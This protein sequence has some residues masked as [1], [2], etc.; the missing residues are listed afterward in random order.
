MSNY[1]GALEFAS[2]RL[3]ND[4]DIALA[5]VSNYGTALDYAS[6]RLKDNKKIVLAAV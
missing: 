5:A 6:D 4:Y 3:K 2:N 1:G